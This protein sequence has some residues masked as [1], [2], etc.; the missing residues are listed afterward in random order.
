MPWETYAQMT[1]VELQAL[2]AYFRTLPPVQSK[3]KK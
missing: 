2:W 1:D 3:K